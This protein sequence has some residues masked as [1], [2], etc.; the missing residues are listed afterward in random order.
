MALPDIILCLVPTNKM[1]GHMG[2]Q[3]EYI[4]PEDVQFDK[5]GRAIISNP[6]TVARLRGADAGIKNIGCCSV[7]DALAQ[8]SAPESLAGSQAIKNLGCCSVADALAQASAGRESLSASSAIKNLGCCSVADA[9]AQASTPESLTASAGIKNLGCCS[10]AEEA[11]G[12][13]SLT[14][15]QGIKNLG[16]CSISDSGEAAQGQ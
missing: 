8:A 5:E 1:G 6:Q 12:A 15:S 13:E 16:C 2:T 4:R 3:G 11:Q 7:A 10:V 14:A 9:L